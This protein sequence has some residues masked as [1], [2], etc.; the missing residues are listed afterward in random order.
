MQVHTS[1][2]S[3]P[4][5]EN[6]ILTI[7][8]YDGVHFGHQQIINRINQLAKDLNTESVL[9]TFHPHPRTIVRPDLDI[10]LITTIEEKAA[11]M[12]SYGIDHFVVAP[13]SKE[14]AAIPADLYVKDVLVKNFMPQKI[15]IGY[16]HKFGRGAKGDIELLRALSSD[17]NY[18][19]EEISKQTIDDI[20]VSSTKVRKALMQG[21]IE[22]ANELLAHPFS[23]S[24][25]VVHGEKVGRTLGFPTANLA[26]QNNKLIPPNGV[27]AI[28]SQL[29]G[30]TANG[31]LSIGNKPTFGGDKQFIE[32]YFLDFN[33]DLYDQHIE[34][35]LVAKIRDE[36]KFDSVEALVQQ[37][38]LDVE[39]GKRYF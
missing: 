9:L 27:Y 2:E 4:S 14:F 39:N 34:L 10:K 32:A 31:L 17:F 21:D 19:V 8:T 20:S 16:D 1:W 13:F 6:V 11:L 23:I 26:V 25:K 5:F 36:Q 12:E 18:E 29:N 15:V 7:G 35:V 33:G 24:G 38:Q 37:M 22:T 30:K 28:K 3:L